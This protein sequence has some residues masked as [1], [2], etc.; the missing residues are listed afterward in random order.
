MN[1][2][3][4]VSIPESVRCMTCRSGYT[5]RVAGYHGRVITRGHYIASLLAFN[6]ETFSCYTGTIYMGEN[7]FMHY[8]MMFW[9][10]IS[11]KFIYVYLM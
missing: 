4:E 5:A 9:R 7:I 11:L 10:K 1:L 2:K 6:S 8:P 3:S